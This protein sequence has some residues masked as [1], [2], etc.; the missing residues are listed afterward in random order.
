MIGKS[1]SIFAILG[2][3]PGGKQKNGVAIIT[4]DPI[5]GICAKV[6]TTDNVNQA[7]QWF[8]DNVGTETEVKGAGIDTLLYWSTGDSGWRMVDKRLKEKYPFVQNSVMASNALYGAMVVQGMSMAML[9]RKEWSEI[10]LNE[11][12]PK[13]Q[14]YAQKGKDYKF[15]NKLIDWFREEMNCADFPEI[16]NEHQWDALFSAWVTLKAISS[17]STLDLV[18]NP[19]SKTLIFPVGKVNYYW[20]FQ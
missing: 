7:F 1:N 6:N 4:V 9:L 19:E 5:I 11:T 8:T 18:D 14:Y 17:E 10:I 20:P 12:H 15:G 13:V 3:D 2:Y 16:S